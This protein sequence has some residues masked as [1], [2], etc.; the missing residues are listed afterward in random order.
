MWQSYQ[1]NLISPQVAGVR[2]DELTKW[3][4]YVCCQWEEVEN[5]REIP[6][7]VT[8]EKCAESVT[9]AKHRDG[10]LLRPPRCLRLMSLLLDETLVYDA[11][12][13]HS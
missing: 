7:N 12:A 9:V 2:A 4:G 3:F 13:L 1:E 10:H 11:A 8:L 6:A 5:L